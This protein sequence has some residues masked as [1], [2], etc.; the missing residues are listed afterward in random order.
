MSNIRWLKLNRTGLEI[1]PDELSHL[2]KLVRNTKCYIEVKRDK[3]L[4]VAEF[5]FGVML[6]RVCM[7]YI[8]MGEQIWGKI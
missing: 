4:A 1:L 3:L 2:M 5:D 6:H 8:C 7:S